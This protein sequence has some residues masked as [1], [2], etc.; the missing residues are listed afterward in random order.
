MATT[1][2][3]MVILMTAM[4]AMATS[5]QKNDS[6]HLDTD[7]YTFGIENL[8]GNAASGSVNVGDTFTFDVV[9]YYL[10]SSTERGYRTVKDNG[11]VTIIEVTDGLTVKSFGNILVR[12]YS[13]G[14]DRTETVTVR[15]PHGCQ[16]GSDMVKKL[17]V[18][19]N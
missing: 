9:L 7:P 3:F 14:T 8:S 4:L 10:D 12:G 17:K 11:T 6:V 15:L 19:V 18:R 5:C 16:D 13:E 2:K 1:N